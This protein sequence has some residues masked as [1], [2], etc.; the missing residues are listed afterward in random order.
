MSDKR[1]NSES[2]LSQESSKLH[3][4]RVEEREDVE[5]PTPQRPLSIPK[6]Q[7]KRKELNNKESE[8][9]DKFIVN[10][11][12]KIKN[13]T[14]N[15]RT[16]REAEKLEDYKKKFGE[17]FDQKINR[18]QNR[19]MFSTTRAN[20]TVTSPFRHKNS[21]NT[22]ILDQLKVMNKHSPRLPDRTLSPIQPKFTMQKLPQSPNDF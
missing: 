6:S 3:L 7:K 18:Q 10:V 12:E 9:Q 4:P 15:L 17:I 22:S 14:P 20:S 5:E 19:I 11:I 13:V 1:L 8:T 16:V 21:I 2:S